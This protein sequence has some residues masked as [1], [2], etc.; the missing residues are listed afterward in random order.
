ML[1]RLQTR[2]AAMMLD[3]EPP[4]T[5]TADA[6]RLTYETMR[7]DYEA[8]YVAGIPRFS[9]FF[10]G[11]NHTAEI[12]TSQQVHPAIKDAYM[13]GSAFVR[14][15]YGERLQDTAFVRNPTEPVIA[16]ADGTFSPASDKARYSARDIQTLIAGSTRKG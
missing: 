15:D 10:V 6:P 7:T 13:L 1:T 12:R 4:E 8:R 5:V 3:K 9:R 14:R 16:R 11:E 2:R